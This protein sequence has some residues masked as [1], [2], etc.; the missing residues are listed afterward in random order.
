[1]IFMTV[2]MLSEGRPIIK[3]KGM[4]RV[5]QETMYQIFTCDSTCLIVTGVG[6]T[7]AM[8]ATMYMLTRFHA[9]KTDFLIS[10]GI[11]ALIYPVGGFKEYEG[12]IFVAR[13]IRNFDIHRFFYPDMIH[14]TPFDEADLVTVQSVYEKDSVDPLYSPADK[15]QTADQTIPENKILKT[16][17][18][19]IG[20]DVPDGFQGDDPVTVSNPSPVPVLV[21]MEASFVYEATVS[22]IYAHHVFLLKIVSD[23]GDSD[24][25][26]KQHINDLVANHERTISEFIDRLDALEEKNSGF[27]KSDSQEQMFLDRI[28][29]DLQLTFYQQNELQQLARYF[30][31]R[32]KTLITILQTIPQIKVKTKKEGR[33]QYE[34]LRKLLMEP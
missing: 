23:D 22:F 25:L 28:K 14:S 32:K 29:T 11:C 5:A 8:M 30:S 1:M 31:L 27:I 17:F 21:D 10:I 6:G 15:M 2:A 4:K 26:T 18:Q 20:I 3:K 13:S 24:R 9:K 7:K 16:S 12:R 19:M 34:Q 33:E